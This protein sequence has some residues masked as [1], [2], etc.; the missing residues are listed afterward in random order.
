MYGEMVVV[1][2]ENRRYGVWA[3]KPDG[4]TLFY[5]HD[6]CKEAHGTLPTLFP[7]EQYLN[8]RSQIPLPEPEKWTP[9][10]GEFIWV[11][12]GYTM[13]NLRQFHSMHNGKY[14]CLNNGNGR[15]DSWDYAEPFIGE[16]PNYIKEGISDKSVYHIV[17]KDENECEIV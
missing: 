16:L 12:D 14:H 11:R 8:I 17:K 3:N 9:E 7:L 4:T 1:K 2:I 15:C 6:G 10:V 13:P 5:D